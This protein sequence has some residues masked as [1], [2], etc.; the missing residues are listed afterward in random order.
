MSTGIIL[1][2][3]CGGCIFFAVGT[4]QAVTVALA[5]QTAHVP[6]KVKQ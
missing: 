5:E 4:A 3:L 2:V 1:C 6:G